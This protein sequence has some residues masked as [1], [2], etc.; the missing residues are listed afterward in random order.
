LIRTVSLFSGAAAG[1][2][3][4]RGGRVILTV[5]FFGSFMSAMALKRRIYAGELRESFLSNY[6][7]SVNRSKAGTA[8][9]RHSFARAAHGRSGQ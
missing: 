5:S 9:N 8:K 7:N 2:A 4:T 3:G 1:F 6:G